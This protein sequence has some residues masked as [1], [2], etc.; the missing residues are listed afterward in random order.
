MSKLALLSFLLVTIFVSSAWSA[1]L[2]V[3][4]AGNRDAS[5]PDRLERQCKND[6]THLV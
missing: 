1:D 4:P 5:R 6:V 3:V 2:T